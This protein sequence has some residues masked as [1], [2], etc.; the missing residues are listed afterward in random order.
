MPVER[1]AGQGL[2]GM[3]ERASL[4]G[5]ELEIDN[6]PGGGVRVR[7]R[8]PVGEVFGKTTAEGLVS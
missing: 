1:I 2:I 8:L 7:A 5:G 3:Q 4:V 6:E